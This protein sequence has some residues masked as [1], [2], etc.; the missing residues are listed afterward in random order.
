[1]MPS[2]STTMGCA[3]AARAETA[4]RAAATNATAATVDVNESAARRDE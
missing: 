1:M 2:N 4:T 3:E